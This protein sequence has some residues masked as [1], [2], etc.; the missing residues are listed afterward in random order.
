MLNHGASVA[1]NGGIAAVGLYEWRDV[2][3]AMLH[4][5]GHDNLKNM[6]V[7]LFNLCAGGNAAMV[8]MT[9]R[10][11]L[12]EA[13]KAFVCPQPFSMNVAMKELA[14]LQ[15][16]GAFMDELDQELV[17]LGGFKT[18]EMSPHHYAAN[19]KVPAFIIQVRDD[20]W[21]QPEDV[22]TTFDLLTIEDK[23]LF[24]IEGTNK[25]FDG[26]NYFGD[27]PAQMIE[28]FDSHIK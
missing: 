18:A 8:A 5:Q 21:T 14:G 4:V 3:G 20:F 1:A 11:E 12:F 23:K 25:R 19:V 6:S 16:I 27:N 10:P 15:G 17:K 7:G 26:Y 9:K 2:V 28:F 13:V 22:Q 24:W